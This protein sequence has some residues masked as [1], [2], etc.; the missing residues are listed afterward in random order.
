[1]A[2]HLDVKNM[3]QLQDYAHRRYF[4]TL[5]P[6]DTYA[7]LFVPTFWGYHRHRLEP[8]DLIRVKAHDGAFDVWLTVKEVPVGGIVMQRFP[9]EPSA[10]AI[11]SAKEV[12]NAERYVPYAND[13]RPKVRIEHLPATGWRVLGLEG[14]VATGIKDEA[15]AQKVMTNYLANLRYAMPNADDQAAELAKHQARMEAEEERKR[16]KRDRLQSRM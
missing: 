14:E 9:V 3:A 1:M 13:G 8:N 10:E 2:K 4:V 7:D 12:G 15:A 16:V 11:A 6:S 5:R